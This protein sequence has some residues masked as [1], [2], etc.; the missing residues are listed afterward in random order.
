MWTLIS[1]F[2]RDLGEICALLGHYAV[3]CG[4]CLIYLF[5]FLIFT[6]VLCVFYLSKFIRIFSSFTVTP[7]HIRFPTVLAVCTLG[8]PSSFTLSLS[9]PLSPWFYPTGCHHIYVLLP[10]RTFHNLCHRLLAF[11]LSN[12]DSWPVKMGPIRCPETSVNSY[13]TTPCNIPEERRSHLWTSS[14][15]PLPSQ[16]TKNSIRTR[17]PRFRAYRYGCLFGSV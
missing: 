13:H 10:H 6:V 8:T 15:T 3:S 14:T 9:T 4:N 11:F 17:D 7:F 5:V 12:S 16:N 2:G 1:G